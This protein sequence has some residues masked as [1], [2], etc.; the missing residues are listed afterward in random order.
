VGSWLVQIDDGRAAEDEDDDEPSDD[1]YPEDDD[2]GLSST[3]G[4]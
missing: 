2:L 1:E 3:L 4:G